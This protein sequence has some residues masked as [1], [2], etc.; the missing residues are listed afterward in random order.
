MLIHVSRDGQQFGPYT[1]EDVQAYLADG[2]L[3]ASDLGWV[4]GT[5]DWVPLPQLVSGSAPAPP[6]QFPGVACPKCGAGLD[7]DQVVC[8][9]C[10]HNLDEP[11]EAVGAEEGVPQQKRKIPPSLSYEDELA[12][13]A[14]FVNSVGWGLLMASMLPVFGDGQ[15]EVPVWKFWE[16][17]EWQ[18]MYSIVAPAVVGV[19]LIVLASAM[20]G[21][22]RGIVVLLLGLVM[23]GLAV[24][25]PEIGGFKVATPVEDTSTP[26]PEPLTPEEAGGTVDIPEK[27]IELIDKNVFFEKLGFDPGE[28]STSI[29][30]FLVGWLTLAIG[31][32]SRFYR[33]DSVI[34]YIISLVGAIGVLAFMFMPGQYGM[35][36]TAAVD[37]LSGNLF[38]GIGLLLMMAMLLGAA[39]L[40]FM[41]TLGRR[42]SQMK[43][44]SN[45]AVTL[46]IVSLAM[47]VLPAWGKVIYD[48]CKDD[49]ERAKKRSAYVESQ[50]GTIYTGQ[51][52]SQKD[53]A[54]NKVEKPVSAVIAATCG[55]LMA[56]VKYVA[57]IGGVMILLP[58]GVIETICGTRERDGD[59]MVLQQ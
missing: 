35:P 21:R 31:T 14:S 8:L 22:N 52:A 32:K 49:Q 54:L 53:M 27:K 50:F 7:A 57:W 38:L 3:L 46:T 26:I 23:G 42:P 45:L 5:A 25:D 28:H 59:F 9:A 29:M 20:H 56:G 6:P 58:L 48:E 18:A 2:S 13:R 1:P 36:L 17:A 15:W 39:V 47:P 19:I 37:A 24:A 51:Q 43:Q 33:T 10:G 4:E 44:W 34:A 40:C 16:L 55:W 30:V 12:D 41:N 11:V